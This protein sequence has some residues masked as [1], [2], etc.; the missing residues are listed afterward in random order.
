METKTKVLIGVILVFVV[1]VPLLVDVA[2]ADANGQG[3]DLTLR[4]R[5]ARLLMR[6]KAQQQQRE[7]ARQFLREAESATVQG[8]VV[9]HAGRIMIVDSDGTRL[10]ILLPGTWNINSEVVNL[11][12][13]FENY[14]HSGDA[15]T[16]KVLQRTVT[17]ENNVTFTAIVA[18]EITDATSGNHLY[19]VL[20]FNI[21]G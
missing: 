2:T 3:G 13:V 8:T 20:P 14:V 11:T 15:I 10:N 16:A 5:I 21:E 17:N 18:Y 19:A 1:A 9:A 12:V 7:V 4:E 6:L